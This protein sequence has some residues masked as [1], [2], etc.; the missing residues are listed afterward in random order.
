MNFLDNDGRSGVNEHVQQAA[1]QAGAQG[2]RALGTDTMDRFKKSS[3]FLNGALL[4][5]AGFLGVWSAFQLNLQGALISAY[6]MI[7][8]ACTR[9][10]RSARR[11]A[12]L[13]QAV[14]AAGLILSLFAMGVGGDSLQEYFGFM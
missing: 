9:G 1:L 6:V 3:L 8:G 2:A 5:I 7:F 14:D 4:L 13:M 12:P 10:P 11:P